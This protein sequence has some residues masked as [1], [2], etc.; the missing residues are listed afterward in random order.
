[1]L[2]LFAGGV[3]NLIV[4]AALAAVVLVEKLLPIGPRTVRITGVFLIVL[5]VWV[6]AHG[7]QG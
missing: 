4:I 6:L 7:R 3:M 5:A 2:L 1:M